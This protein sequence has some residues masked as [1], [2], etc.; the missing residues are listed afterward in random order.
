MITRAF[1][2]VGRKRL[3]LERD[4]EPRWHKFTVWG[5][6]AALVSHCTNFISVSYF[7]QNVVNWFLLL[8]MVSSCGGVLLQRTTFTP[9]PGRKLAPL[10]SALIGET[11]AYAPPRQLS[12][13][14]QRVTGRLRN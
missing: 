14:T 1:K 6:G 9:A 10:G 5:L 4:T 8:A 13:Q 7:D 11:E 3:L 12:Q 2:A